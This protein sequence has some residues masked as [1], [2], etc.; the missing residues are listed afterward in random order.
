[1][2]TWNWE[3]GST[4]LLLMTPFCGRKQRC[5][6]LT[7]TPTSWRY[8]IATNDYVKRGPKAAYLR[9]RSILEK[10]GL[11]EEFPLHRVTITQPSDPL[12][13]AIG[14]LVEVPKR[15]SGAVSNVM[16]QDGYFAGVHVAC[17]Y[18]FFLKLRD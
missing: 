6:C 11:L 13:K 1:M 4:R 3:S 12:I 17:A 7:Q 10:A 15:K 16:L 8:V 5:G 9:V 18:V 2:R 14:K